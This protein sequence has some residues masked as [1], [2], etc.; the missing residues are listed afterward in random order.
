MFGLLAGANKRESCASINKT[1]G[2]ES[3]KR[4]NR[5]IVFALVKYA[6]VGEDGSQQ[7]EELAISLRLYEGLLESGEAW[8]RSGHARFLFFFLADENG[9]CRHLMA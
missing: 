4:R 1:S 8:S 2:A 7:V 9:K 6:G 5:L 3:A